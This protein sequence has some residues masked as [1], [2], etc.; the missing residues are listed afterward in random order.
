MEGPRCGSKEWPIR[1]DSRLTT[2]VAKS[3]LHCKDLGQY[4]LMATRITRWLVKFFSAACCIRTSFAAYP[5]TVFEDSLDNGSP[6]TYLKES[7]A[8][9]FIKNFVILVY[10]YTAVRFFVLLFYQYKYDFSSTRLRQLDLSLSHDARDIEHVKKTK[11]NFDPD[12]LLTINLTEFK[13]SLVG[14]KQ[15][16]QRIL[17]SLGCPYMHETF[18]AEVLYL[19]VLTLTTLTYFV[20]IPWVRS[21]NLYF[22]GMLLEKP[23]ELDRF[24]KMIESE[25]SAI[26]SSSR[27]F[28]LTHANLCAVDEKSKKDSLRRTKSSSGVR[29]QA[30]DHANTIRILDNWLKEDILIPVNYSSEWIYDMCKVFAKMSTSQ[31]VLSAVQDFVVFYWLHKVFGLHLELDPLDIFSMLELILL[32]MIDV[33]ATWF[34]L[35][36]FNAVSTNQLR[37]INWL[38]IEMDAH[39]KQLHEINEHLYTLLETR[40]DELLESKKCGLIDMLDADSIDSMIKEQVNETLLLAIL[41]YKIFGAQFE[42][43][44]ILYG[45]CANFLIVIIF[46]VPFVIRLHVPYLV[47]DL[48]QVVG[49]FPL[50][51]MLICDTILVAICKVN[52]MGIEMSRRIWSLQAASMDLNARFRSLRL[53]PAYYEHSLQLYD[54]ET[55]D[56]LKF[57]SQF[58]VTTFFGPLTY[59][60]LVQ[61]HYW[62]FLVFISAFCEVESWIK[63]LGPRF[64]DPLGI[65][66][67][68]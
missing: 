3:D 61:I 58:T 35:C 59:P 9:K 14:D 57:A 31:L 2:R 29:K 11:A 5:R 1:D 53:Q 54:K 64:Y 19:T 68:S 56:T 41:Q 52:K 42:P 17:K 32:A 39:C 45:I 47:N 15:R 10:V 49:I 7:Y 50:T 38:K 18:V 16:Y 48:H 33:I 44:R 40:R 25:V 30:K 55:R 62:F 21:T 20:P 24:R 65:F 28:V 8:L 27:N 34:Y 43:L 66:I 63:L 60:N 22:F 12:F 4:E 46:F 37:Y 36:T 23:E 51:L 26:K 67:E 13:N 6:Q